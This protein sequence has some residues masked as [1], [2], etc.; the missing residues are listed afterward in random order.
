MPKNKLIYLI[1]IFIS[2]ISFNK[3]YCF[4]ASKSNPDILYTYN[5]MINGLLN[6][7]AIGQYNDS[8]LFVKYDENKNILSLK[9]IGNNLQVINCTSF[10]YLYSLYS[11]FLVECA[12]KNVNNW[13]N[14]LV[15]LDYEGEVLRGMIISTDYTDTP[16]NA[17]F[18]NNNFIFVYALSNVINSPASKLGITILDPDLNPKKNYIITLNPNEILGRFYFSDWGVSS[19]GFIVYAFSYDRRTYIPYSGKIKLDPTNLETNLPTESNY[20][21]FKSYQYTIKSY[22]LK[23]I[24]N[25]EKIL[26]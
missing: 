11:C 19:L 5:S 1:I 7:F 8:I 6:K 18:L 4:S 25:L 21:F 10:S 20:P 3:T 9:S 15:I 12:F 2:F 22:P 16:L 26:P 13:D 14:L 17:T 24:Y 23:S